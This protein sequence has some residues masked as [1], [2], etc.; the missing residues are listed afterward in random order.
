LSEGAFPL[1][2]ENESGMQKVIDIVTGTKS[3]VAS[4]IKFD[5]NLICGRKYDFEFIPCVVSEINGMREVNY[6]V[7]IT[8]MDNADGRMDDFNR[9]AEFVKRYS[10]TPREAELLDLLE[11]GFSNS[12]IGESLYISSHTV[13][14]H[15]YSIYRKVNVSSRATLLKKLYES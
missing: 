15:I 3:F 10:L 2:Y 8:F 6:V 5:Y 1:F 13:K 4:G 9:K 11:K 12:E 7:F 14:A